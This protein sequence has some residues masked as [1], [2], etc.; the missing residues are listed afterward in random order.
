MVTSHP[1][2][3]RLEFESKTGIRSKTKNNLFTY[4]FFLPITNWIF[5]LL[6]IKLN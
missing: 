6:N 5:Q 2:D 1:L 4:L 3:I